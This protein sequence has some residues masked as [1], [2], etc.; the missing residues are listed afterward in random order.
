[1]PQNKNQHYVPQAYFRL[2]S[3]N[4]THIEAYNLK[5][6][7]SFTSSIKNMC[8]KDYFYS[9]D[10]KIEQVLSNLEG[11]QDTIMRNIVSSKN[12]P[13]D[14]REYLILLSF[15]CMQHART[16]T[17][18]LRGD[19][20]MDL[21]SDEIVEGLLGTSADVKLTFPVMHILKIKIALQSIPLLGDL[22]PVVMINRTSK[23]F[24]FSDNPV[25]FHNT[26]LNTNTF[27][28]LGLQSP[29][30]QIF[31][32]LGDKVMLMFYD[33]KFYSIS[34]RENYSLEI[35]DENDVE[36]LNELQFLNCNATIFYSDKSQKLEVESIHD[37]TKHLTGKRKMKKDRI[38]IPD[39][40]KGRRR[41]LLHFY[42]ERPEYDLELSFVKM[43][44][45][46]DVG[47]ARNQDMVNI[48]SKDIDKFDRAH[49]SK[50]YG[51]VYKI[52]RAFKRIKF[53]ISEKFRATP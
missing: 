39:D 31:C 19:E 6:K 37:R 5:R 36:H 9:K 48:I 22:I 32:P 18:K 33:R 24:I 21:L 8:S 30:L 25:V 38:Q 53:L 11:S 17:A 23:N 2:F 41:E 40:E 4:G 44:K 51:M 27:G 35:H 16:E 7:Q 46:T 15:I 1:M 50:F 26:Y 43:N 13:N 10:T 20:S 45:V 47:I 49:S 34:I 52:E 29:G 28:T 42:E 3:N 12:F 14:P